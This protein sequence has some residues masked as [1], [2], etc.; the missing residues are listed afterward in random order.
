MKM[1]H[2]KCPICGGFD[3]EWLGTKDLKETKTRYLV[4]C[5]G[6]LDNEEMNEWFGE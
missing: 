6:K 1:K 4:W 2:A 3:T 5:C